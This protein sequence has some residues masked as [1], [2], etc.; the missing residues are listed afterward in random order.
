MI[1][2]PSLSSY[3]MSDLISKKS[4]LFSFQVPFLPLHLVFYLFPASPYTSKNR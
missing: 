4:K 1:F 2:P 3:L